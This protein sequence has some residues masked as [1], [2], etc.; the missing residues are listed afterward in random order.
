MSGVSEAF[1]RRVQL[2]TDTSVLY[3]EFRTILRIL[4]ESSNLDDMLDLLIRAE[5][6]IKRLKELESKE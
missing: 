4:S 5:L 3:T 2:T 1:T 6:I